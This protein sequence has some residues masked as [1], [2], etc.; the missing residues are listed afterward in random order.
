[1]S[2]LAK[3]IAGLEARIQRLEDERAII[4]VLTSYGFA[5]DADD[6]DLTAALYSAEAVIDIDAAVT[7]SGRAEIADMVRG[8]AHQAILPDCAH[9]MGP[10]VVRVDGDQAAATGYA[11][12]YA[13]ADGA[14]HVWRQ[15][16]A[17]FELQ[18]IGGAWQIVRRQSRSMG[19]DAAH[20]VLRD[21]AVRPT[22]R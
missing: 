11:T 1:M 13:V 16:A 20:D 6:P 15:A 18:R 12:V 2:D 14:R 7:I 10:F 3:T 4:D 19:S 5:V 17:R 21:G 22:Q 9:V 8:E